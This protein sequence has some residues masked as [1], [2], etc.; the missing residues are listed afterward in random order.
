MTR[1]ESINEH[2]DAPGCSRLA[3]VI[4][5]WKTPELTIDCLRSIFEDP[6]R[7]PGLSVFVVDNGSGDDSADQIEQAVSVNGWQHVVTVFRSQINLGFAGGNNIAIQYALA[8]DDRPDYISLLNPDTLVR[9]GAF[10]IFVDFMERH[11]E[12]GIAGGRS[13]D[14]DGT[15]QVCCFRFPNI[16]GEF[17][18]Y[19]RLNLFS[20]VAR[21]KISGVPVPEPPRLIDWVS[22]AHMIILREVLEQIG[23][24]D[25]GYFLYFEETDFT[26]RAKRAGWSCWHVPQSRVV[27]FVGQSSGVTQRGR[28]PDRLPAY[29][30]R[31]RSR[32]F[33]LNHGKLYAAATDALVILACWTWNVR[34]VLQRKR[35]RDPARFLRD[36]LA[37]SVLWGGVQHHSPEKTSR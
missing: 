9:P 23:L 22:G 30:F 10:R 2:S 25:D 27:H 17:A 5:N 29:W 32:Y 28:A 7:L 24:L 19:L 12:V 33:V 21:R 36:L 1:P 14:P 31:S 20:R 35:E 13:E 37:H 15:P 16:I 4:V 26:I 11:Q 34:R 6:E 8:S 18:L 3:V